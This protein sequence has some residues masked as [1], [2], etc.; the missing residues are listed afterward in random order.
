MKKVVLLACFV[1]C[2]CA[3]S[4]K[5]EVSP[6]QTFCQKKYGAGAKIDWMIAGIP[7]DNGK[8]VADKITGFQCVFYSSSNA[9]KDKSIT[10]KTATENMPEVCRSVTYDLRE[11]CKEDELKKYWEDQD[12][13]NMNCRKR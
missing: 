13:F 7:L 12:F 6:S 9:S 11:L 2:A 8:A 4:K 5:S 3:S 10:C 1:A